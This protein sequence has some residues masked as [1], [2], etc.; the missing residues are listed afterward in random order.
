MPGGG[1]NDRGGRRRGRG[2]GRSGGRGNRTPTTEKQKDE[3]NISNYE[4]S[5]KVLKSKEKEKSKITKRLG[6]LSVNERNVQDI[7]KNHRL[8]EWGLGQ[9]RALFVYDENQYEKERIELEKD[10]LNEMVLGN[11]DGVSERNREILMMDGLEQ[12]A[13]DMRI[14]KEQDME[15]MHQGEDDDHGDD[16]EW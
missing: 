16:D 6:D 1:K 7:M 15:M 13:T 4:I 14:Q 10:M 5:Q 8:G 3:I 9:T 11:M 2:S 12:R